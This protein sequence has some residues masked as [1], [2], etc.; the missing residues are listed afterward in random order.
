MSRSVSATYLPTSQV[1]DKVLW[2]NDYAQYSDSPFRQDILSC[3]DLAS[4]SQQ[5]KKKQ[6][7]SD[8]HV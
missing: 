4:F 7:H 1:K 8:K 2:S 6:A 5:A 3:S